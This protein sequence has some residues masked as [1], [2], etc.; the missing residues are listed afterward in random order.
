MAPLLV[1]GGSLDE[2]QSAQGQVVTLGEVVDD[3]DPASRSPYRSRAALSRGS[4]YASLYCPNRSWAASSGAPRTTSAAAAPQ[5]GRAARPR[6]QAPAAPPR[7]PLAPGPC[8]HRRNR[9]TP[10]P[11]HPAD[12]HASPSD[13][14]RSTPAGP[15]NP[16]TRHGSR[17]T[18]LT[19][20]ENRPKPKPQATDPRSRKMQANARWPEIANS[21]SY[22]L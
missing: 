16:P 14:E 15:W 20:G 9:P 12:Q 7:R 6:W 2:G 18:P 3:Q 1:Y 10:G 4:S 11:W 13:P 17:P 5:R 22:C 21:G 8:H 19:T